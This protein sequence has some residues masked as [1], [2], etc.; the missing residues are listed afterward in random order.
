MLVL[1]IA[2]NLD[3]LF[4]DGGLTAIATLRVLG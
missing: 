1:S 4:K 2:K 3:E